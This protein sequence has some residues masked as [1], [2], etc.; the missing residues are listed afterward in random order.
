MKEQYSIDILCLFCHSSFHVEDGSEFFSGDM[1]ECNSCGEFNDYDSLLEVAKE[2]ALD[3]L[4]KDW[5][6]KLKNVF[7]GLA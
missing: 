7:K 2:R 5:E 3:T 4:T 1:L 6:Q